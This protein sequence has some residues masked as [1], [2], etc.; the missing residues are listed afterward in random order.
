MITDEEKKEQNELSRY[1]NTQIWAI[2]SV[3]FA[4]VGITFQAIDRN[5]FVSPW[6]LA[7][8]ITTSVFSFIL[9]LLFN[10]TH[11]QQLRLRGYIEEGEEKENDLEKSRAT[12]FA[13]SESEVIKGAHRLR[14]RGYKIGFLQELLAR[15][16]TIPWIRRVMYLVILTDISIALYILINL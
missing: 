8:F 9:L 3:L 4:L 6:N 5:T 7:I 10:K 15:E 13:L 2:P 11:F 12:F 16:G 14:G 1:Y